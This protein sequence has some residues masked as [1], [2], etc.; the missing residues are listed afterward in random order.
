MEAREYVLPL[1]SACTKNPVS[2]PQHPKAILRSC[3]L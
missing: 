2:L 1:M 3:V